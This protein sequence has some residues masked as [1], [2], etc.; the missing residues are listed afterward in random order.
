M[1]QAEICL[2]LHFRMWRGNFRR[3]FPDF[4]RRTVFIWPGYLQRRSSS[5]SLLDPAAPDQ[6]RKRRKFGLKINVDPIRIKKKVLHRKRSWYSHPWFPDKEIPGQ[7]DFRT[8]RF[9]D[10]EI[11]GQRDFRTKRFPDK[12]IP[13]Q[14][15]IH[16]NETPKNSKIKNLYR[17]LSMT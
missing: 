16:D 15:R 2:V 6:G 11:P 7:R 5:I 14:I 4:R 9:P 3:R 17:R 10:K 1:S 8:K 12:E 13:G